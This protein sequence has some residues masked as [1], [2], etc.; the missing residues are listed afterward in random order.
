MAKTENNKKATFGKVISLLLVG[1]ILLAMFA[2]CRTKEK[3]PEEE[4]SSKQKRVSVIDTRNFY[5]FE[6]FIKK[7][8]LDGVVEVKDLFVEINTDQNS[9]IVHVLSTDNDYMVY[10]V[11]SK[12][13]LGIVQ[14]IPSDKNSIYLASHN[15][16]GEEI[17][18][19]RPFDETIWNAW[20]EVD[21]N[22]IIFE[23]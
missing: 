16:V 18:I 22:H 15:D 5:C 13:I 3:T 2:G 14:A 7:D 8:V 4:F 12:Q 1:I 9:I 6:E 23:P 20:Y 10:D 19:Q 17:F 11:E 21:G